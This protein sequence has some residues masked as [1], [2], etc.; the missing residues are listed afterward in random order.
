LTYS[1]F[2]E[3]C[4]SGSVSEVACLAHI[5]RKFV[6]VFQAEGSIIAEETI[7][8]IAGLYAIEKQARGQPPEERKR[9][10]QVHAM[11]ILDDL[12]T[13][14]QAQLTK[15]S[16]KS[17]LAKAIR[18]ALTRMKKLRPYLDQ[19]VLEADNNCAQ[20]AMKP[21]AIGRKK[22]PLRGLPRRWQLRR[23]RLHPD[24]DRQDERR[25]PASLAHLGA[26]PHRRSEDDPPRRT[27]ALAL[28]C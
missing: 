5:R 1:G 27:H 4:R 2:N 20:R 16:G 10:R 17:E 12:E 7:R 25:Q 14:L 6:D 18:Y 13:W 22:L 21:I 26:R 28:R 19:R 23:H 9:L 8:R 24:R 3:L 15:I 11:P